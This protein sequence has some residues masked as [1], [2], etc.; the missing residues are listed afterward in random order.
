[1][2]IKEL[3][4]EVRGK[5]MHKDDGRRTFFLVNTVLLASQQAKVI[6]NHTDLR[7]KCYVGEMGVDGWEKSRWESEFNDN[8]VLVMTAQVFL[9]LLSAGFT[10]LS[11][12][13]LLIFDECHHARKN[14]PY[15]QIMEFFNRSKQLK[16]TEVTPL[17][18][19]MG[20]TASVVNGKVKLLR[21]ESEIKQLECTMWSKCDTTCD[22]DVE[23]F[24]TKPKEQVL[25]YS[26]EISEDLNKLIQHLSQVLTQ[27]MDFPGDCKVSNDAHGFTKW[28]LEECTRTLHELGPWAAYIVA[29]YLINELESDPEKRL[30]AI[31]FVEK[32]YTALI[33]SEQINQ[34]AKLNHDLSF[35]KS[36]FVTGHGTGGK[37]N[38]SSET[39]MN[40]KKQE[41]VLRKF[42]RHEFNVL[43]ATSVVEEGLDVPKCNVVCCF[44]FPKNFRSYVQSK[45]RA[46]ARDSNYYMLVPQELKGEKENDLEILR[47]IEKILFKRCHDRTQPS[48]RECIESLDTDAFQPYVPEDGGGAC[49]TMSN[50]IS[51]LS[52]YCSKLPGDRFT[53]PTPVYKIEEIGKD[54][55][56]VS[57][58]LQQGEPMRSKKYAKMAA[59]YEACIVLHRNGEL[60]DNLRPKRSLSDDES[61]L[62]EEEE[63]AA[64]EPGGNESK[65]GSK[66]RKRQYTRKVPEVFVGSLVQDGQSQFLTTITIQVTKLIQPQEFVISERLFLND[67]CTFGMLTNKRVP[68][69]RSFKLYPNYGEVTVSLQCHTSPLRRNNTKQDLDILREFH[70][71]L[72]SHVLRSP[73]EFTP[74][75]MDGYFIVMVK[76]SGRS[77][78]FDRMREEL[79]RARKQSRGNEPIVE[80]AVVT[81]NYV[82][83][84]Q[85]YAVLKVRGDLTPLSPFPE[86]S[87]GNTYEEYFRR[88]YGEMG[89]IADKNQP[90]V[91]AKELSG[92]VNFLVD[93]KVGTKHKRQVIYLVPELCNQIPIRASLLSVSQILPSVLQ[94]VTSLLLVADLKT[95]VAGEGDTTDES[96]LPPIGAEEGSH[97]PNQ[98]GEVE[99]DGLDLEDS[100]DAESEFPGLF[101][102]IRSM[103]RYIPSSV[104][105]PNSSLVL[106]AVT[107]THSG[108]AFNL[109]RLEMLGD[110]FLKL[111][112]SLHLFCTYSDKDEGKLT[113]R[114]T[115]QISNLALYRAA[116]KKSLGEYLQSTQLARDVWCPTGCQFGDVPPNRTTEE[117]EKRKKRKLTATE[118][119]S[120]KCITQMIGDKSIADSI[121]ALIG[122]Y[123]I[124]DGYLG[125]LRFMKFLGLK[126]LPEVDP[127]D[128]I[129]SLAKN[130]K[131]GCYAR[132]WPDQTNVTATQGKGDV[133]FR[134]TSG[135]ENFESNS[136]LYKFQQKLY[137]V[138]ALTHASYHENR[139]TPSYQ[140]LEFLGDAL[141]DFLVT[142]HLYFRHVNLSPGDLT[143]IRQ[144]LV[145]ADPFIIVSEEEEEEEEGIEAPKVLGDIFE[146]VAGAIFLDSGMDL[147]KIWGVYYRMMEPCIGILIWAATRE[148]ITLFS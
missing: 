65:P 139:A 129:E 69:M 148:H 28:A 89:R 45:G 62:E 102:D 110:S 79:S 76:D 66:K 2:L 121:E 43:I 117:R 64:A 128:G 104:N 137:L 44:D 52:K 132:F 101:S 1:M 59:A 111:A 49:V 51:I 72:F 54:S 25:S 9:N 83:C 116:T 126:I 74:E 3:A 22:E 61:E 84:S 23:N 90:L 112:V 20:L 31:V 36:N 146:S 6:A 125:A 143:D 48:M 97:R 56:S 68:R 100:D 119:A 114:K 14:H 135:L 120:Q 138:E 40:F 144:A 19:I 37:V 94:R 7:V 122:A 58:G 93:R 46:R 57:S 86:K 131:S 118:H 127:N 81:K 87:Q 38:F 140:R 15:A 108:D 109:E 98:A 141:L 134:L 91:E 24:A 145:P 21:I 130:S 47:E 27:G 95:M 106:Q 85:K 82:Q 136:I 8:N 142:Q 55:Y 12:V 73:V 30:C 103:F 29:A 92:R 42:R 63:A 115:N 32:R 53:Q 13:N 78:D 50:S 60:D 133:V 17:P 41:E 5:Y 77:V 71:F 26:N 75:S 10:K 34:A 16:P 88:K 113:R 70:L 39:E 18:K 67:T 96:S 80:D 99:D 107:T 35:V 105:H 147:T 123:L 33:L 11:Q 124:S 4:H